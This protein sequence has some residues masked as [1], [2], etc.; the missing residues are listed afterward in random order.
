MNRA[1]LRTLFWDD[2][3]YVASNFKLNIEHDCELRLRDFV[4][5]G[6]ER[7]AQQ[8]LLNK[9]HRIAQAET[10]LIAFMGGMAFQARMERMHA[11]TV[12][13][14][15]KATEIFCPLWPFC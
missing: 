12:W 8:E 7:I 14:F 10:H 1:E 9:P 13:T 4:D 5:K 3:Q 15:D 11:L 2:V 6:T